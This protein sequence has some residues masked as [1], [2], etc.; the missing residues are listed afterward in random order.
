MGVPAF[1]AWL[2]RKYPEA[3]SDLKP[4]NLADMEEAAGDK[5]E[6][7]LSAWRCDNLYLD[8]N[9]IIHPCCHPEGGAP[10]PK[11]EQEMF[12][13]VAA[14]LDSLV[15]RMRP[16][17]LVYLAIDGVAPRAKMNQ[18]RARRFR[19]QAEAK[20][21]RDAEAQLRQKL[22]DEGQPVPPAKPPSW[23]H[24]V[25]TPGTKFMSDL[26]SF[27]RELV[28]RRLGTNPAWKGLTV[29]LSDASVPGEGEHKLVEYIRRQRTH[30]AYDPNLRHVLVGDDA[31]LI[32]LALATHEAHFTIVRTRR[33]TNESPAQLEAKAKV[34]AEAA[35][36]VAA[37]VA[38]AGGEGAT[39]QPTAA[40]EAEEAVDMMAEWQLLHISVIREYL[41]QEFVPAFPRLPSASGGGKG[42]ATA[43][44]YCHPWC[45]LP[46]VLTIPPVPLN[47][48]ALFCVLSG[49]SNRFERLVDDFVF[50][51]FFVG[52]DFLPHLPSLDIREGA[53]DLLLEL[54][55]SHVLQPAAALA[56]AAS[57]ARGGASAQKEG[58]QQ[59]SPEPG[60]LTDGGEVICYCCI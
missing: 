31:D 4:T 51:C 29:L 5:T 44:H 16:Q 52:N 39:E 36:A 2:C 12:E 14:L 34:E 11:S 58:E 53:L 3:L 20:E 19:S 23:D 18:Q 46:R 28:P 60:W 41:H 6:A 21:R 47:H 24:N 15:V 56:T 48:G 13:N 40:A 9:G 33:F 30:P 27:L 38:A 57:R 50:L 37:A 8:M 49:A 42:G 32:M 59:P 7:M 26:A 43:G 45:I 17:R 1:F 25:I 55:R 10:Q 35:A 22:Q 54:Y